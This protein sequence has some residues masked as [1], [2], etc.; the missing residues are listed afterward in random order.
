MLGRRKKFNTVPSSGANTMTYRS[1]MSGTPKSG[2]EK[3]DELTVEGD[4]TAM[5]CLLR[6]KQSGRLLA[7]SSI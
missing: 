3:W 1:T 7:V 2:T 6:Y 5:D 4:I